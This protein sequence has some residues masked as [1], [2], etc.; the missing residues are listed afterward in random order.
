M[1]Q[2]VLVKS[3]QELMRLLTG[4][5]AQPRAAMWVFNPD[6]DIW[7]L[8]LVPAKRLTDKHEFYRLLAKTI[9]DN[10]ASLGDL[11]IGNIEFV[12][13]THPAIEG[14]RKMVKIDQ[15]SISMANNLVNNFYIPDGIL[16]R[17]AI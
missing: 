2:A 8:W 14:L 1:D 16:L 3:G 6:T 15:G 9:S 10:R 11:D 13:D 7:R 17:M 12:K 5:P 4:T